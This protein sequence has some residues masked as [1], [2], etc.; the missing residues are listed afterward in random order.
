M[1]MTRLCSPF[2]FTPAPPVAPAQRAMKNCHRKVM[3]TT[4][5]ALILLLTG[6]DIWAQTPPPG[7]LMP[8]VRTGPRFQTE[9]NALPGQPT[10]AGMP[11][12]A[13]GASPVGPPA[14]ANPTVPGVPPA[15]AA[16][17]NVAAAVPAGSSTAATETPAYNY[18][19]QGVDVNQVLDLYADLVGRTLIRAQL[20]Q[21][22]II[23]HTQSL[24]TKTEAIQAMQAVLALNGIAIVNIGDKFAK[25]VQTTDANAS[26]APFNQQAA[27]QLPDLGS[28]VTHIVQLRNVKPS[29]MIPIIQPFA[30]LQNSILAIDSN[31]ILVL[32]DY[33]EN[34]KRM[35]E[36]IDQIDVS[37]PAEYISE[38]I[39]IKYA[40]AGDIANALGSLG[41]GGGATVSVGGTTAAAPI[42]GIG[43]RGGGGGLGGGATATGGSYPSGNQ[44][45][46]F[47]TQA[48]AGGAP[49]GGTTFQQRLQAIMNRTG[50]GGGGQQDQI[51]LFGQTKIIADERSNS[52]L[53]FATRQDM[54]TITNI[55]SKLDVLLSQVLVEAII[56]DVTLGHQFNLGVSAVQKPQVYNSEVPL[57]GA[58]GYNNGQ[59]F[60]DFITNAFSFVGSNSF[61]G[62]ANGLSFFGNIGPNWDVAVQAA[63][64]DSSVTVIQRP[65]IQTSQAKPAQF[66]VGNTVPYVTGTYYN[67][68]Y[69]GGNSSQYNQ[70]SVGVEL[71]VTPFINP[72]GLVVMDINQEIDDISGETT[73]DGNA[74][75]TTDKRTLSSEIVVKNGDTVMLGGF[76][77]S[78]KSHSKSGVPLLQ[79]IPIL[80]NL[81]TGRQD[82]KNRQEL[83]VMMRPTVLKTPEIAAANTVREEQRLPGVS[84]AA[85]ENLTSERQLTEAERRLEQRRART[86]GQ[87]GGF[88]TVPTTNSVAPQSQ[89]SGFFNQPPPEAAPDTNNFVPLNQ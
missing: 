55:I 88:Y 31:G 20:P 71:D 74:V 6:F 87:I 66:F 81:F 57:A 48:N 60:A 56:M 1:K 84:A 85:A 86:K 36:M 63:E 43:G 59:P 80:G 22:S 2:R 61:T 40:L 42:T 44:P 77:R 75:P 21:A 62:L 13:P 70:L 78:D 14:P 34:V 45:R 35:L 18:N 25:V 5:L 73:I 47:G 28:Y 54:A 23:L 37:V 26:G 49:T 9:T 46:A 38:V 19:L 11:P 69:N 79:D 65:R 64:S 41:G 30:K 3:K 83:I 58:G 10:P 67:G 33:A 39:P 27:A 16:P 15:A 50:G 29:E 76:I 72:D 89:D 82:N 17:T 24:L 7:R 12:T 53:I 52:L 51:Q 4:T 8:R 32:R 68:G